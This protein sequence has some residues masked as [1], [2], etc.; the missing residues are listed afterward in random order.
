MA[1]LDG[2]GFDAYSRGDGGERSLPMACEAFSDFST[3][4]STSVS[5]GG[6]KK[7]H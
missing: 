2:V 4:P 5:N 7:I 3:V 6:F 1:V